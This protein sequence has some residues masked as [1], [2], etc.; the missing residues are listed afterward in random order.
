MFKTAKSGVGII[1]GQIPNEAMLNSKIQI[2]NSILGGITQSAY[3]IY[4]QNAF[5]LPSNQSS[6]QNSQTT[7]LTNLISAF[8]STNGFQ[9][10]AIKDVIS[11]FKIQNR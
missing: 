4:G 9:I 3:S 10:Q 8:R 2:G 1:T 7:S 5:K 11:A 6:N